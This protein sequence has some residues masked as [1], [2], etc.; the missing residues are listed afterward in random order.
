MPHETECEGT[1]PCLAPFTW[2]GTQK[3]C[4]A[5]W[6]GVLTTVAVFVLN[7]CLVI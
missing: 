1:D 7:R 2:S 6:L 5:T 3:N 4:S